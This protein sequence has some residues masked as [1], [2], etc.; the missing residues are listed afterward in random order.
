MKTLV[1]ILT[2]LLICAK[3]NA[4]EYQLGFVLG[5]PTGIYGKVGVGNNRSVDAVIAYSLASDLG[6]ELHADY[7]FEKA[8]AFSINAKAPLEMYYGIGAR[9]AGIKKGRHDGDF[10]FGPRAP[11]GLSYQI[12]NPNLEIFGELALDLDIIPSTNLDLEGGLGIRIRF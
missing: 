6:L 9:V 7:L 4:K 8:H 5:A 2:S 12:N 1:L 11:I 3:S 10:A